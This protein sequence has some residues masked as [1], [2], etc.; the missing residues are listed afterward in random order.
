[1]CGGEGGGG[2]T[3]AGGHTAFQVDEWGR[4]MGG[5]LPCHTGPNRQVPCGKGYSADPTRELVS[6]GGGAVEGYGF[7]KGGRGGVGVSTRALHPM[8]L[9][10]MACMCGTDGWLA[11]L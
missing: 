7:W 9:H 11:S 8:P 1:V 5:A 10:T 3:D 6:P 4:G 2:F